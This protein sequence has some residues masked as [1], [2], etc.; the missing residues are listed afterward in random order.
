MRFNKLP[1]VLILLNVL[2]L[3]LAT[4]AQ[5][6]DGPNQV[7]TTPI[8]LT[9]ATSATPAGTQSPVQADPAQAATQADENQVVIEDFTFKPAKLTVAPGT[10]VTWI[11]KDSAPHTA[12][13]T[14][15]RFNSGALDTGDKYTFVFTDKGDYSYFCALHPQMKGHVI[16]K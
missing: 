11:N 5:K 9:T 10:S 7:E 14:E 8:P 6:A 12:T 1:L 3:S 15:K 13:S 2:S 16:I 4:C